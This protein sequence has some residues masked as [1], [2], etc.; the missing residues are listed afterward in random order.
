MRAVD[1]KDFLRLGSGGLM[2]VMFMGA[3]GCNSR[4]GKV[5]KF[6]TGTRETAALESGNR[7]TR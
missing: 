6:F 7:I 2:A 4:Q 5:V 3:A 1:R